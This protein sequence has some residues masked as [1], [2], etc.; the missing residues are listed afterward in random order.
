LLCLLCSRGG[1][2]PVGGLGSLGGSPGL[3]LRGSVGGSLPRSSAGFLLILA[4]GLLLRLP[5]FSAG[6]LLILPAGLSLYR[7]RVQAELPPV[8][9]APGTADILQSCFV[10]GDVSQLSLVAVA[11]QARIR[12][13]PDEDAMGSADGGLGPERTPRVGGIR[14]DCHCQERAERRAADERCQSSCRM[15]GFGAGERPARGW[16]CLSGRRSRNARPT[17]DADPHHSLRLLSDNGH[18]ADRL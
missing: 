13:M 18:A 5:G 11:G 16:N 3:L 12:P 9:P 8:I 15:P 7:R 17:V 1:L 4:A 2:L 14:A 10:A 6:L